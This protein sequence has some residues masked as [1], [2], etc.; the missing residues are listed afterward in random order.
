MNWRW[1]QFQIAK[2]VRFQPDDSSFSNL[3]N[4]YTLVRYLELENA[5][6]SWKISL[7]WYQSKKKIRNPSVEHRFCADGDFCGP[8]ISQIPSYF[9]S[10]HKESTFE[11][12]RFWIFR[13]EISNKKY[14]IMITWQSISWIC[15][16]GISNENDSLK[17]GLRVFFLTVVFFFFNRFLSNITVILTY[18]SDRPPTS[19][20]LRFLTLGFH[21]IFSEDYS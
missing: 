19:I 21:P 14:R 3:S 16:N 8:K 9:Q 18:G 11:M 1:I 2:K 10:I 17:Y 20:F 12:A 4:V 5:N 13:N 7:L 15:S 6:L